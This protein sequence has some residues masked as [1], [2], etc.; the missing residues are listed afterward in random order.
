MA[1][2]SIRPILNDVV[3]VDEFIAQGQSRRPM[4]NPPREVTNGQCGGGGGDDPVVD[5]SSHPIPTREEKKRRRRKRDY[6]ERLRDCEHM[7][8]LPKQEVEVL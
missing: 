5:G 2:Y 6:G 8:P 7:M 4:L 3:D 1:L